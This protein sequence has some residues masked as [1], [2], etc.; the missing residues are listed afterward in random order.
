MHNPSPVIR[1]ANLGFASIGAHRELKFALEAYWNGTSS[2]DELLAVAAK[3][4]AD[5]WQL[6]RKHGVDTIPS[7]DATMYDRMLDM[8]VM[9]GAIPARFTAL[10]I[11][12]SLDLSFALARGSR[13]TPAMEITKWFDT[14]YHYVV[15][16]LKRN[17][18]FSV[19]ENA[20]RERYLEAQAVGIVTRPVLIGPMTYL[21][22]SRYDGDNRL[23]LLDSLLKAYTTILQGL[24]EAGVREIQID[25]PCLVTDLSEADK[26]AYLQAYRLLTAEFPQ[27]SFTLATYFG[28]LTDNLDMV[29]NLGIASLHIDLV[30]AP[31]QLSAVLDVLPKT[32]SLS[33]GL[34]NGR[35][36]WRNDLDLSLGLL[37]QAVDVLGRDRVIVA[38]SCSLMHAPMTIALEERLDPEVKSWLAFG[39]EKLDEVR[40]LAAAVG[41]D[42]YAAELAASRAIVA[43]R[44]ASCRVHNAS[45]QQR[46][47]AILPTMLE[48]AS[49][50]ERDRAQRE[51]FALPLLPTTTI[52]SLP[53]T[54]EVRRLRASYKSGSIDQ[55]T[56]DERIRAWT[57]D[58]VTWQESAGIDVIV[59]GEFERNDMVEYF[60]ER[61]HG[62]AASE[63]AW[64]VSYGARCVK[65]P[66]IYGDV[67][68]SSAMTVALSSYAQSLTTR[69]VKGMLTGPITI[70][71]W[72]FVRE[73]IPR[74]ETARQIALALRDEVTELEAAGIRIIQIDEPALREGLPLRKVERK[75]YLAWATE[76]FRLAAAGAAVSTQIHTHMCYAEFD[77]IIAEIA[78]LDV[79][80]I[81]IES[82]RSLGSSLRALS[83]LQSSFQ[84][85]PGVYDI[86]SPNVP[87]TDGIESSI[88]EL[89]NFISPDRLWINPDCG[90]KTRTWEQVRPA[91][92]AMVAAAQKARQAIGE[93]QRV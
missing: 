17:Q 45:V 46:M 19:Q 21:L 26:T 71:Q 28:S 2:R 51:T 9:L 87:S 53:Q 1:T 68:R 61:L 42:A 3:L 13:G 35:N 14:N 10:G 89:L 47:R 34:I 77:D 90:L 84:I 66:I 82:A 88:R 24:A 43:G 31:E 64:V 59:H 93:P 60:G 81:S 11:T 7:N 75:A 83:P 5:H 29:C 52:G 50:A 30:R 85:G 49:H 57:K 91:L 74:A 55:T 36:I 92:T 58:A 63:H 38:P 62:F 73:D 72:S 18:A 20:A 15:P 32:M 16:E 76:A 70:L 54:A 8:T 37:R 33:C 48:R 79:D 39:L 69:P 80:V 78:A 44:K 12:D 65:P 86:H 6:Q 56:Y 67:S 27:F 40:I 4:R 25:E 22:L 23:E 41:S